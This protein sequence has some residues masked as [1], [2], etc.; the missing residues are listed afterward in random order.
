MKKDRYLIISALEKQIIFFA[1]VCEE[2]ILSFTLKRRL[3]R[4]QHGTS[5]TGSW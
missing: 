3:C 2:K 5:V 4:V 1:D